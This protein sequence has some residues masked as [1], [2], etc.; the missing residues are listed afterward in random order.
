[1]TALE[2]DRLGLQSSPWKTE[3]FPSWRGLVDEFSDQVNVDVPEEICVLQGAHWGHQLVLGKPVIY[4][5]PDWSTELGSILSGPQQTS[6][7]SSRTTLA[8]LSS[9]I[10]S[11]CQLEEPVDSL[12]KPYSKYSPSSVTTTEDNQKQAFAT[13]KAL[14]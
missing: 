3:T 4:G 1:M 9:K 10:E 13:A 2:R 7:N 5:E 12:K 11:L 6:T 14:S 8:Y